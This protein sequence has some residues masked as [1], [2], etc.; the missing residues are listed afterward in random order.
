MPKRPSLDPQRTTKV[1][2]PWL[3]NL[4][5]A[6]SSNGRRQRRY[7]SSRKAADQFAAQQ[8]IRLENYGTSSTLLP[9][10][11]IEEAQSAFDRLKGSGAT[12]LEAVD[13]FLRWREARD[14]SVTFKTLFERFVESRKTRSE[15]Y[16]TAL[17]YTLPRFSTL[18][19]RL[20][21]EIT[22]ADIEAELVGMT[23]SVRNAFLRNLRA[24]FNFGVRQGWCEKNPAT[25]IEIHQL[26]PRKKI[27]TNE[28]VKQLLYAAD[29]T[30]FE[31]LPYI[32]FCIFAGI[33]PKEVERLSWANVNMA[34]KFIEVP[35]EH[36]KT[37]TRRVVDMEP[38]LIRWIKHYVSVGG[39]K[40]GM[41]APASDLR[42]RLRAVRAKA[43]FESWPQDAPR[44][45]YASCW[46]AIHSDVNRLNNLMGHTSP[47]ML[48]R[49]YHRAVTPQQARGFW[50]IEPPKLNRSGRSSPIRRT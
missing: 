26:R 32:L 1:R 25:R 7:F 9:A 43:G 37:E 3:I 31:L 24:A 42:K 13:H 38:L 23:P 6:L 14:S 40:D 5:P 18:H 20:T 28:E 45:T 16:R 15:P 33:R 30:D 29:Q 27:L 39:R 19:D 11:K 50:R 2:T 10:G 48:W 17:R 12:L 44:R 46:L 36:S 22:P 4:P 49:H 35:E 8:R 41:I 21:F 47:T 34:E